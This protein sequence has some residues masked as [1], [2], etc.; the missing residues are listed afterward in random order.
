[1]NIENITVLGA[2]TMGHGIA[3]NAATAGYQ[4]VLS[5]ISE[6]A[7]TLGLERAAAF[8]EKGVARGK[9]SAEDRDAALARLS[10][11]SNFSLAVA[12]ADLVIE[13]APENL[14]LK[15]RIFS[16]LGRDCP[17]H[18]LLA[19]NTSSCSVTEMALASGRP[20]RVIG[21]HFF[22]PVPIM[23]LLEVITTEHTSAETLAA[24]KDFALRL[25]KTTA[26]IKDSPGFA[27]SRLGIAIALEAIRMVEQGVAEPGDID[28]CMELGYR[29][30][31][32][33]LR[34]TDLVGLDVRLG[35]AD[36]IFSATQSAVFK[37]PELL[38]EMVAAGKLGRKSGQG[39]YSY[40]DS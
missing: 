36:T 5:D 1:M 6:E 40:S 18:T 20:D 39:F 26:V 10:G 11:E 29:F 12:K 14:E 34:L 24:L 30:P 7:V 16:D 8:L 35:I 9:T 38:R 3:V 17:K 33:P 13:A 4:V 21:A 23:K 37:A 32:G 2:G 25:G 19:S 15:R 22:N 27:T 31:M 28:T